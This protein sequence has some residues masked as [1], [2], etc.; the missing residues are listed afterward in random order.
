MQD[1]EEKKLGQALWQHQ[2][3]RPGPATIPAEKKR[4]LK[5]HLVLLQPRREFLGLISEAPNS[6]HS[7]KYALP[8]KE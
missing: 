1:T 8:E 4:A 7:A 3:Q 5:V 6:Y 2:Q